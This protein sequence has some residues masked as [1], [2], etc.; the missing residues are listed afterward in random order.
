MGAYN[1]AFINDFTG[2]IVMMN[3]HDSVILLTA[4]ITL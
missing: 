1:K 4:L 3:A 2:E